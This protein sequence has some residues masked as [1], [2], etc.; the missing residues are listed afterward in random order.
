[1]FSITTSKQSGWD[2][3]LLF[4]NRGLLSRQV[5]RYRSVRPSKLPEWWITACSSL[6]LPHHPQP[7]LRRE[8]VSQEEQCCTVKPWGNN[9]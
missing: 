1:M 8:P 6:M 4:I 3:H 5:Q 2:Q 7:A 9:L